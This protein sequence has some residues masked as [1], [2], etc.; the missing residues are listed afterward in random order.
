[1]VERFFLDGVDGEG[2][3]FPIHL[4]YQHP[5]MVLATTTNARLARCYL[6]VV[7]TDLTLY[8]TIF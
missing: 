7:G 1:M 8:L 4:A 3:G 5:L 6:A 2:T